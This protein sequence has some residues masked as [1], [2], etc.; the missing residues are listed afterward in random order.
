MNVLCGKENMLMGMEDIVMINTS[1]FESMLRQIRDGEPNT[2]TVA[3][4]SVE[5]RLSWMDD[6]SSDLK[7]KD[8]IQGH[9]YVI[10]DGRLALYLG[11]DPLGYYVFYCPVTATIANCLEGRY[12]THQQT[13]VQYELQ[14]E[15]VIAYFKKVMHSVLDKEVIV[16]LK[17]LPCIRVEFNLVN[18]EDCYREWYEDSEAVIEGL[19]K[20]DWD[21]ENQDSVSLGFVGAKDLIPGELYYTGG[22]WRAT[23]LYLGRDSDGMFCWYFVGNEDILMKNDLQE[24]RRKMERS[25]T[26]KR[27]KRLSAALTDP[28]ACVCSET[29]ALIDDC[30]HAD[31]SGIDLG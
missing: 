6:G 7:K 31:L 22:C 5:N 16:H 10:K 12:H 11:N 26:N 17:T 2:P 1:E 25:K 15:F 13:L 29:K 3:G 19:P 14:A 8:L 18:F 20:I 30:W 23:Y 27:C 28:G 24:Y 21:L 4:S 9:I